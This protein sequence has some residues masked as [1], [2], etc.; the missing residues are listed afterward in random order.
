[1][2]FAKVRFAMERM[3]LGFL[4][5][6]IR[7]TGIIRRFDSMK[8]SRFYKTHKDDFQQVY[9][10][11]AD[12]FSKETYKTVIECL[13][14]C[15]VQPLGKVAVYPQYFLKDILQP[16]ADGDVFIDGGAYDGS[17]TLRFFKDY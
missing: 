4:A 10:I 12:D 14:T 1:M 2:Y 3:G 13:K 11:L 9:D 8:F 17:D 6:I 16:L 5:P 15:D 7:R